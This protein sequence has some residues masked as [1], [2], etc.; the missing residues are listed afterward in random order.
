MSRS[1]PPRQGW[2]LERRPLGLL[3]GI[4]FVA[5]LLVAAPIGAGLFLGALSAFALEPMARRLEARTGNRV[6]SILACCAFTTILIA[7]GVGS[8]GYLIATR[9]A[10][11]LTVLP[12]LMDPHGP[13]AERLDGAAHHLSALGMGNGGIAERAQQWL[14]GVG[15]R[16]AQLAATAASAVMGA[17]LA[18]FFM[19]LTEFFIL[20]KWDKLGILAQSML[21]I[22]PKV[23]RA[24]L[25]DL[26]K[27]GRE[28]MIGT[29][30]VGLLQ[31]TLAG[32]GYAITG[33][34]QPALLGALTAVAST[35]PGFGTLF[36]WVPV[37]I[38]LVATHHVGVGIVELAWGALAVV[39]ACDFFIRPKLV[40]RSGVGFFPTLVSIFGGIELFGFIGVLV[41]PTI[42]GFALAVLRR[43]R[44][45]RV[46]ARR[47]A[48]Q[49]PST[50]AS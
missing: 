46:R 35:L 15:A 27:V 34:P 4:A 39:G 20:H 22:R 38:F 25:G 7:G 14:G 2:G 21:P 32:I 11:A 48:R 49:R 3:A 12:K 24:L 37:G 8:V 41:G 43:Y 28:A 29:V 23:T 5:I 30:V 42:V 6:A 17:F 45:E 40:G 16:A 18:F 47:A 13:V 26:S 10:S 31:G 44:R 9:G 33:A 1:A 50:D 19:V 36:V